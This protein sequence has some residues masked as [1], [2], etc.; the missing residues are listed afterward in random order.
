MYNPTTP[1]ILESSSFIVHLLGEQQPPT[2]TATA[3]AEAVASHLATQHRQRT[4]CVLD[5]TGMPAG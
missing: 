4:G 5:N 2:V 1:T 3:L